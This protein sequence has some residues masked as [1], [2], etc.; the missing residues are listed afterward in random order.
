MKKN[1]TFKEYVYVA[2]MLF[3]LF[4]GAGN[5][6]F[7]VHMGQEAGANFLPAV[8]GFL[9]TGVGLP[10][11]GV[12]ALGMSRST[13]LYDLSSKVN[14]FFA[15]TF[16][17]ALY[18]SI[19]PCFAIPRC[20]TT[21]FTVG[22]EHILPSGEN[23]SF[24]L[25]GFTLIFFVAALLF[26]LFPGKILTW[27]GKILN[28]FFLLFLAILVIVALVNPSATV[29][30]VAVSESYQAS[31]FFKG[32][33][34]GYNTMDALASLAFGIIVVNVIKDLGVKE[35]G[36]VAKNTALSGVF[37]CLL[38]ALIYFAT[39]LVGVQSR[40]LFSVSANG[41]IAL[42]EI[43]HHYL[44]T[45]GFYILAITVT[46][47]CLKTSVGLIT[48]CSETFSGL[49][50]KG[51]SYRA[52]VFIFTAFSFLVS[53]IGLSNIIS[54]S[55]PVLMFL[56]PFTITLPLLALFGKFFDN[57]RRIYNWVIALTTVGSLYDF[58]ASLPESV[59]SVGVINGIISFLGKILP[60]SSLGLG[61][62]CPALLGLVIGLV[63]RFVKKPRAEKAA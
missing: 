41:G 19:G 59:K 47:A 21:A 23:T 39:T 5:L 34:E 30:E 1:L 43:A 56:Y 36:D 46:L 6:I 26:S 9:V 48:S 32:F 18:L 51:P 7:P 38:M 58:L 40:G 17:C 14:P 35:S 29:S 22:I 62:I 61:W 57:D 55:L 31:P 63:F 33:I 25:L 27:V 28:P 10:L 8:L 12:A 2:S 24:F 42:A 20:A 54:I 49:F 11:L 4:F 52:W 60:F 16:T 50:K 45:A 15:I 13:G 3:G 37:S 44:G 53:N